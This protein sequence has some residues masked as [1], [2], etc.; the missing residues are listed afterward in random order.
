[1]SDRVQDL[2]QQAAALLVKADGASLWRAYLAVES[3]ILDLK[4]R[5]NLEGQQAPPAPKRTA[6]KEDL[7]MIAKS[8][9][10]ALD[11]SSDRKKLLYDLRT[12]RDAL[13]A[14]VAKS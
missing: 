10:A 7:I 13:K 9:L 12:C 3:A 8:G 6:K 2:V 14:A 11:F 4:L 1:M 5:N